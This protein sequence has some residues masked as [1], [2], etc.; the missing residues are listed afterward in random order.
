MKRIYL[1]IYG[2]LG[3]QL[4]ILAY[5]DYLQRML[6]T[7]PYL[8]NELERTKA[9]TASID[10][11]RRD[12][13]CELIADLGFQFVDTDSREFYLLKKWERHIK[14]YQEE[15]NKH[16]VYLRNILPPLQENHR[17]T[18]PLVC[19]ISGYF[20]SYHYVST[21][22]RMR[23]GKF[24]A[25]HAASADLVREYASMIQ[26]EDVAIHLRRG[27]FLMLQHAGVQ[28]FGAK[29]YAK[30][31]ALQNQQELVRR[32]FVFSDDFDAI[33]EELSML[34]GKYQLVLVKGLPPLQD[35]FLLTCFKRYVLANS[36][37]SWWG[38]LCS[39]YGDEV[40]VVVPSKPL[41][42]SYPEDSYFPS[43]WG[44]I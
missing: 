17:W 3:N 9:D 43:S 27:D 33:Q 26:P 42:I 30:G 39:Q 37:F 29:H 7:R 25:L 2:G 14:H 13:F 6:G 40:K 11:T 15:L 1:S 32:V 24:L 20:Q 23:V 5:A 16:G 35:L 19:R 22:F 8:L 28:I 12:L 10:R 18:L 21:D 31:L 4:Y 34:A 44:Q 36:T 38:A 41:L